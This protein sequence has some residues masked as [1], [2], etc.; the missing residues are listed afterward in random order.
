MRKYAINSY[1]RPVRSYHN[2]FRINV[3]TS[4]YFVVG[5]RGEFVGD[6]DVSGKEELDALLSG[7]LLKF[8]C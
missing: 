4:T 3:S 8:A 7:D 2:T 5:I 1:S 6:D